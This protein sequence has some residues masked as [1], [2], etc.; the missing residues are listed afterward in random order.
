MSL[1]SL[2]FLWV[3]ALFFIG[4][5]VYHFLKPKA[6]E[7]IV[8]PWITTGPTFSFL[9]LRF[10]TARMLVYSSGIVEIISGVLLIIPETRAW[11]AWGVIILLIGVFPANV[12]MYQTRDHYSKIPA[13]VLLTRLPVQ[14]LVIWWATAYL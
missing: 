2:F 13:W 9:P 6:F 4:A 8:P 3:L 12:Y 10:R 14:G 11:G 5:G 1:L 7:P